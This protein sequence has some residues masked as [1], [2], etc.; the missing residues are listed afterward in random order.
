MK[1]KLCFFD[2]TWQAEMLLS[3]LHVNE[4][5][6][7]AILK[8]REYISIITGMSHSPTEIYV[9]EK[10]L[11]RAEKLLQHFLNKNNSKIYL[12]GENN[13]A[14]STTSDKYYKRVIFFSLSS[15]V[16]LP[17]IFNLVA[18][19]NYKELLKYP[20]TTKMKSISLAALIMGLFLSSF[21]AYW[22]YKS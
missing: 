21:V 20:H 6:A 5:N 18:L 16:F 3:E 14:D 10:D 9:E 8:P 2:H 19:I 1:K 22:I 17:L 11:A 13:S 12:V 4:I 15:I 7:E